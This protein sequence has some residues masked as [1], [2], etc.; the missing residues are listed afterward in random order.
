MRSVVKLSIIVLFVVFLSS[1]SFITQKTHV[2]GSGKIVSEDRKISDFDR[3]SFNG[4]GNLEIIQGNVESLKI[5]ADDNVLDKIES[6][7]SGGTLYLGSKR[8][9]TI[10]PSQDITYTL[11]VRNLQRIDI[12]GYGD[13]H[14]ATL[15]TDRLEV[16]VS[17]A[18]RIAID[19]LVADSLVVDLSGAGDFNLAGKVDRQDIILSGAGSYKA[20]DLQSRLAQITISGAGNAEIWVLEKMNVT[21]SGIGNLRYYGNPVVEQDI[22]GVGKII[23]LGL[24]K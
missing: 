15:M 2:Q 7:V 9:I 5:E 19:N 8:F 22:T 10:F 14:A 18:G 6:Y 16:K 24:H 17:G 1:C 23:S 11:T 3:I 21:L 20:G 13:I 4:I 12:S